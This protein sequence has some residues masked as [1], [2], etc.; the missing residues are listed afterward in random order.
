MVKSLLAD[1]PWSAIDRFYAAAPLRGALA[2]TVTVSRFEHSGAVARPSA[3]AALQL[4]QLWI[5]GDLDQE[6]AEEYQT[7]AEALDDLDMEGEELL[8]ADQSKVIQDMAAKIQALES[9]VRAHQRA[10]APLIPGAFGSQVPP[11]RP[12]QQ[13]SLFRDQPSSLS[14]EEMARLQQMAG[15]LPQRVGSSDPRRLAVSSSTL[16]AD[17]GLAELEKGAVEEADPVVQFPA[18]D[19]IK[20]PVQRMLLLQVQQNTILMQKLVQ[21]RDSMSALLASGGD[22]VSGG[23]STGAK[24][25]AARDLFLRQ[26]QDA[27]KVAEMVRANALTELGMPDEK[28]DGFLMKKYL[29]RRVPLADHRLL[30]HV[31]AL[32]GEGWAIAHGSNNVQ[33]KGFLGRALIFLEQCAL[34]NGKLELAWLMSGFSE[35]STHL[36]FS[37]RKTPGLKPF[38]RLAHP[39]WVSANLAYLK[40]LD[41]LE[42]RMATLGQGRGKNKPETPLNPGDP[43]KPKPKPKKPKKGSGKTG[44]AEDSAAA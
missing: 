29:E 42:G 32:L 4:A 14:P 19:E 3:G 27:A 2:K 16:L 18:L 7:G 22:S 38:T 34:D 8:E 25:C 35:P 33:M 13:M 44:E 24:G 6:T 20:D 41:Y 11:P 12:L 1:L 23:S 15:P 39:L 43:P 36:H 40:D 17:Q 21:P 5:T 10:S 37:L 26:I 9:Q 31:A 30:S 28:E